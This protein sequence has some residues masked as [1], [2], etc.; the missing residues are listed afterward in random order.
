[1]DHERLVEPPARE[2]ESLDVEI[3]VMEKPLLR[4]QAGGQGKI[5]MKFGLRKASRNWRI[6]N[7]RSWRSGRRF[8]GELL[9]AFAQFAAMREAHAEFAN[10]LR[11]VIHVQPLTRLPL[12]RWN[13]P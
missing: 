7:G 4:F 9:P 2:T 6:R 11:N 13:R 3:Q 12:I 8:S 1:M 5:R 10:A